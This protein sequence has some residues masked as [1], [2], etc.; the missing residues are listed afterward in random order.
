MATER[1][2]SDVDLP[3][4]LA[5]LCE[6]LSGPSYIGPK[7]PEIS[8]ATGTK[9]WLHGDQ[10]AVLVAFLLHGLG[11]H[12]SGFAG[13]GGSVG[14]CGSDRACGVLYQKLT[15]TTETPSGRFP[16]ERKRPN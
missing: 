11:S 5:Q 15:G 3:E 7:E 4:T 6:K 2:W 9:G 14:G 8:L 10:V 12:G 16:F 13:G 1:H